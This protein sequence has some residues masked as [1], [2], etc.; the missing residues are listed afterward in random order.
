MWESLTLAFNT[1]TTNS[2][3]ASSYTRLRSIV[4]YEPV[5]PIYPRLQNANLPARGT[6]SSRHRGGKLLS[7]G[8]LFLAPKTAK[9]P[10]A[11]IWAR[12]EMSHFN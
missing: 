5:T 9:S 10:K 2:R 7:Y 8:S 6:D 11:T 1:F 3:L 12:F 4:P